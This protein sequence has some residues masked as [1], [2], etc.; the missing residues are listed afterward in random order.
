MAG[1]QVFINGRFWVSTE[2]AF[3]GR[4]WDAESNLYHYRARSYSAGPGRFISQDPAGQPDGPNR[5][6]YVLNNP[7]VSVDPMNLACCRYR[8]AKHVLTC[9]S[10]KTPGRIVRVVAEGVFSGIGGCLN[11]PSPACV[12]NSNDGPIMP[13]SYKMNEDT[14]I[15]HESY[16][17]L[18][19]NP[20]ISGW[21]YYF[22]GARSGFMLHPGGVSL[23]CITVDLL[24]R[25]L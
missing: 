10:E 22:L 8:I 21:A 25:K 18:E 2:D 5:Y 17:R 1:F 19:P 13:G 20:P 6:T 23:G 24:H 11:N 3:T 9:V 14:R 12:D 16:W 7:L 4:D 15:G